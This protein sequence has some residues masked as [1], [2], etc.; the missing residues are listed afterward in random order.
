MSSPGNGLLRSPPPQQPSHQ[1]GPPALLELIHERC[2]ALQLQADVPTRRQL[3][4]LIQLQQHVPPDQL[5]KHALQ[6]GRWISEAPT[7]RKIINQGA[8]IPFTDGRPPPPWPLPPV[9]SMTPEQRKFIYMWGQSLLETNQ[10]QPAQV[11]THVSP[12]FVRPK[13]LESPDPTRRYRPIVDH[14]RL[15]SYVLHGSKVT[16][17]STPRQIMQL[18]GDYS[19]GA[20]LDLSAAYNHV[21]F[22]PGAR[23]YTTVDLGP[24][25][26]GF[27][28]L[29]R[30]IA[31]L[32][33]PFG[34]TNSPRVFA[35]CV[36]PVVQLTRSLLAQYAPLHCWVDDFLVMA[37]TR[38]NATRA[39]RMAAFYFI[40]HGW[41]LAASKVQLTASAS[42]DYL[43]F[44]W[45]FCGGEVRVQPRR[46]HQLRTEALALLRNSAR[47]NRVP[48]QA[49]RSLAGRASFHAAASDSIRV[50]LR[51]CWDVLA[52]R[53]FR[54]RVRLTQQARADLGWFARLPVA[55]ARRPLVLP[56]IDKLLAS[57]ASQSAGAALWLDPATRAQLLPAYRQ[58]WSE[59]QNPLPVLQE[60]H[61]YIAKLEATA[62]FAGLQQFVQHEENLGLRIRRVHVLIDNYTCQRALVKRTCRDP[63]VMDVIRALHAFLLCHDILL[64][65]EWV[66]SAQQ[67]ADAPSR[68][69]HRDE[70]MLAPGY[71]KAVLSSLGIPW[72]LAR[73]EF[74]DAFASEMTAQ[75]PRFYA[76]DFSARAEAF[77]ALT[78]SWHGRKL[79]I[80]CT[81]RLLPTVIAKLATST[82]ALAVVIAPQWYTAPWYQTLS[83]LT[84]RTIPLPNYRANV[85]QP[86]LRAR[87]GRAI[88]PYLIT[89]QYAA[90]FVDNR[91]QLN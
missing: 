7:A 75:L 51:S 22:H 72:Q 21:S 46:L 9:Y 27:E 26:P 63:R 65:S 74:I 68:R 16:G 77:D 53:S 14:R 37:R 60:M 20:V 41:K 43:G 15:N 50:H 56:P 1:G 73:C 87:K 35:M 67:L 58:Y 17:Q 33:L 3:Q 64:T 8:I 31:L 70:Y 86:P 91:H 39:V 88:E 28:H 24:P 23:R 34:Y 47:D 6:T 80:H 90:H 38:A 42:V 44:S 89:A 54:G 57:D 10:A 49:L 11:L 48:F 55:E 81:V 62:L 71:V 19:Y 13:E 32:T 79:F 61:N 84:A 40:L 12:V 2:Q 76:K 59:L 30:Y 83:A 69:H 85:M 78:Q 29:P 82:D 36:A 52:T 18:A 25:P 4:E 66:P 5:L 45:N